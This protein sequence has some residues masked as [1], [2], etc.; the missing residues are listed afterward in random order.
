MKQKH[1][2]MMVVRN[3]QLSLLVK[4]RQKK[5]ILFKTSFN[6]GNWHHVVIRHDERKLTMLVDNQAPQ[7]IKIQKKIGLQ[8]MIYIGGIPESGTSIP[9]QVVVKLETLKGC[10][11]G[12]RVNGNVLDMV[13]STSSAHNVGQCFPS[14]ESGAYFQDDAYAVYSEHKEKY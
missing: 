10:I 9:D 4:S 6:D 11:R 3:G 2:F 12:L 5:E 14:V 13:G 1:Y 7:S 8:S